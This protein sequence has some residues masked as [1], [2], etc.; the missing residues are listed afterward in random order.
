MLMKMS[1]NRTVL[2]GLKEN[3]WETVGCYN[4]NLEAGAREINLCTGK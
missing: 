2:L 1:T 4:T 3:Q